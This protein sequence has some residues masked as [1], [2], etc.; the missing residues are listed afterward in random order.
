M[1]VFITIG[2]VL[3]VMTMSDF[4]KSGEEYM[5]ESCWPTNAFIVLSY[6][7][8]GLAALAAV[9]GAIMGAVQHPKKIKGSLIGIG[10]LALVV[11]VSYLL[12]SDEVLESYGDITATTSRLSGAGLYA[13]YILFAGS[14]LAIIYS[15]ISRALK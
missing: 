9:G 3:M 7:L 10:V 8:L 11:V 14:I 4:N 1:F 12:A 6:I 13:F 5:C 2:V 15:S